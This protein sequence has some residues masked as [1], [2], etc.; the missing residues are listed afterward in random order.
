MIYGTTAQLNT[1]A[2]QV[3]RAK[4]T[5]GITLIEMLVSIAISAA[6]MT[7]L[8]SAL[9]TGMGLWSRSSQIIE[10]TNDCRF[11]LQKMTDEITSAIIPETGNSEAVDFV[12]N[13][14]THLASTATPKTST[15]TIGTLTLSSESLFLVTKALNTGLS[16]T[17]VAIY[18]HNPVNL[19]I[20][21]AF[22]NSDDTWA[23]TP[24]T[25]R[26]LVAGHPNTATAPLNWR[27]LVK[28][29]IELEIICYEYST[30]PTPGFT[31]IDNWN[32]YAGG[33]STANGKPVK[34]EIR[35]VTVGDQAVQK[36][37]ALGLAQSQTIIEEQALEFRKTIALQ[38]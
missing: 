30:T 9:Q 32:A 2:K 24:S 21:R 25:N 20:E 29:A 27:P 6:I 15:Y 19:T 12:E 33:A 37:K 28:G 23:V 8:M 14:P 34:I 7:V 13:D 36:I 1:K 31:P 4:R 17:C 5:K 10:T 18:R 3:K 16:E 38:F 26:Y 35:I 11:A 22:I